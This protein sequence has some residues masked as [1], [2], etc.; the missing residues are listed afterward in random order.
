M[1]RPRFPGLLAILAV[2]AVSLA[3]CGTEMAEPQVSE[4][5]PAAGKASRLPPQL[6]ALRT[7]ANRLLGGGPGAF[8]RRLRELRG[9][10]VVVNQWASWCGPCRFEFPFF[11]R[12]ARKYEGRMAFLG[13]DSQDAH[14]DAE[15]FLRELP[16]PFPSY[17]DKDA[18]IARLF[19]GGR[20]WP[21]TAFY[22][23]AG[24]LTRTHLGAYATEAKLDEDIRRYAL[25]G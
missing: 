14:G 1:S 8:E 23:A 19:G 7:Q 2:A 16:L 20:A 4:P 5:P 12:L 10:P 6:E 9:H 3:A 21:T 24:K 11:Q 25:G 17:Y 22:D 13:V 15:D 18:S